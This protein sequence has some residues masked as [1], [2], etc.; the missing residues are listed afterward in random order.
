MPEHMWTMYLSRRGMR[1]SGT[2]MI[3]IP[4]LSLTFEIPRLDLEPISKKSTLNYV[5]AITKHAFVTPE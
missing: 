2:L 4:H 3:S 1:I 5:D